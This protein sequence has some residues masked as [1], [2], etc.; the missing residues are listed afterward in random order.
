MGIVF[1]MAYGIQGE[2]RY[3]HLPAMLEMLGIP[4]VGSNPAGHALALDK[5]FTKIIM[6][7]HGIPTPKFWVYSDA[8]ADMSL[9]EYPVIVKPKMESVSYGLQIVHDESGLRKA[10]KFII[11][12]FQQQALVEQFI[13]GREFCVGLLGNNPPEAFPLL[14]IDF[15]DDPNGIHSF[16]DKISKPRKKICP[17]NLSK[18]L[19]DEIVQFS[20]RAFNALELRDFARVDIRVDEN[21]N[22]H[23]LELNSMASLGPTG[24]YVRAAQV[25]G[26]DF[27]TLVNKMLDVASKRYFAVN[28]VPVQN[29]GE[30][31]PSQKREADHVRVRTYLRNRQETIESILQKMVNI[32][33]Y[34]R[35]VEGVN[36]LSRF[37][38]HYLSSLGFKHQ[39][40]PQVDIGQ[41]TLL[42]NSP[43]DHYDVLFLSHLDN[44]TPFSNHIYYGAS[45]QRLYGSGI[46]THKGGLTT[47]IAALQALKYIRFLRKLKIGILLTSDDSLQGRF[48][49]NLVQQ[50]TSRADHV[51]ALK[52]SSLNGTVVTS[53]SGAAVFHCRMNVVNP[54]NA[55]DISH[56]MNLFSRAVTAWSGLS[57]ANSGLVV[58]PSEVSMRSNITDLSANGEVHLSVRFNDP[59]Q[60][61]S[62]SHKIRNSVSSKQRKR[63]HVQIQ[64]G[65][66]RPPMLRTEKID[67]MWMMVKQIAEKLDM[68]LS[69]EHRWSSSDICFVDP[70]I[71]K[72]DGLGP[73]GAEPQ[74][75]EEYIL[76]HSLL[77]RATLL[78]MLLC[79]IAKGG[80]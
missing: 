74:G 67:S 46:W 20:I 39:V 64:G 1:N 60:M 24:S 76:R 34:V 32:N 17:A 45:E 54:E 49:K 70:N 12:E 44:L 19:S 71:A 58:V 21:Q 48:A 41:I 31:K 47:M 50:M 15:E 78:A 52:G 5:V 4:Y 3:T 11:D 62:T 30:L 80:K 55:E 8:Q 14:E 56:A 57:D 79:D 18:E 37:I 53:R 23:L 35:N 7:N 43:N 26:Y 61:Q 36:D 68:R 2:S 28:G 9:V 77:E 16:E 6:Q 22:I 33:T 38:I 51:I 29:G 66:R 25:A 10:V 42:D 27:R 59:G 73:I 69:E 72:L 40:F 75:K 13:R 65:M 63:F